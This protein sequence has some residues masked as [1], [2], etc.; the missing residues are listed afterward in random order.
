MAGQAAPVR[1]PLGAVRKM[2]A[3]G[4]IVA[5]HDDESY[6]MNKATGEIHWRRE[7]NG[8]YILDV[9]VFPQA[10]LDGQSLDAGFGR[11]AATQRS[12]GVRPRIKSSG[13]GSYRSRGRRGQETGNSVNVPAFGDGTGGNGGDEA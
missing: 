8:K 7:E 2:T 3:P 13:D 1:R 6:V 12:S 5:F 9:W 10:D 11:A 4:H